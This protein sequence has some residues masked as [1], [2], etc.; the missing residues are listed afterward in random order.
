MAEPVLVEIE[1]RSVDESETGALVAP[2]VAEMGT[3]KES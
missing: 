3:E 1:V 2:V